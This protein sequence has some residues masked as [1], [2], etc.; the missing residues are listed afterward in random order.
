MAAAEAALAGG[1]AA[2][3]FARMVAA[4]GGP[5]DVLRDAALPAAPVQ[6]AVPAPRAGVVG[7]PDVRALGLAVVALGG[8]RSRPGEAV[9]PR[10]GLAAVRAPGE[11]L[12][13][14]EALAVVHARDDASADAAVQAVL[15]A[16]PVQ[17]GPPAESPLVLQTL[18]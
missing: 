10:V 2:E 9:D 12:A 6:R 15:A 13:A 11:A 3:H 17:D 1:A 16:M 4:L 14:G 7:R 18:R 8:G 5:G